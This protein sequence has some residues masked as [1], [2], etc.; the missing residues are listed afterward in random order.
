MSQR[1]PLSILPTKVL[2]NFSQKFI[3]AGNYVRNL[4]PT[5][6]E[7]LV[8]ARIRI[9][10]REY[11]SASTINAALYTAIFAFLGFA[12][13]N[14][15]TDFKSPEQALA[16]G[17]LLGL[18]IGAGMLLT[19]IFYPKITAM[20]RSREIERELIPATRQ[21]LIELKSGVPLFNAMASVSIDYGKVSNEFKEI[22]KKI[23]S[24]VPELDALAD[25]TRE[26]PSKQFRKVLWQSSNALKV[27]SNVANAL[28]GILKEL[29]NEK[30]SQIHKYGQEL[31]PWT[32]IYMMSAVILPSLGITMMIV[33]SS[34]LSISIPKIILPAILALLLGFQI[35]FINFVNT[36]R[37]AI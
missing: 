32:M 34:F 10:S 26:S 23:N 24:G 4:S 25:A 8:Q 14:R 13:T 19:T 18:V 36:R 27:G 5:L 2:L 15:V 16:T 35:F 37:P 3:S 7:D 9:S 20:R 6:E 33:I 17:L 12:I 30:I 28:E 21:L 29:E 11:A 22:T 1:I 31:S